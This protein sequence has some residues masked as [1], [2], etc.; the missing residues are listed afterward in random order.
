MFSSLLAIPVL[1]SVISPGTSHRIAVSTS[2]PRGNVELKRATATARIS[3]IRREKI[4][5]H[6]AR[7][8]TRIEAMMARLEK[9]IGRIE[10]RIAVIESS[11]EDLD[12]TQPQADIAE[13]KG[14]LDESQTSLQAAQDDIEAVIGN[15]DPK[16]AFK[17]VIDTIG[18]IKK[19]LVE[20]HRLLVQA[21]GDIKGLRV[22][23]PTETPTP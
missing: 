13:A 2:T 11:N 10:R 8:V 6:W 23:T 22:G 19:N 18:G 9:L 5:A 7:M 15:P 1:L 12:T 4:R 21:I 17:Q 20:I 14:L 16:A 3:L